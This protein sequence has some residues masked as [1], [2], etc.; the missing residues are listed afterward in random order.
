MEN[1]SKEKKDEIIGEA[2]E[3]PER[4]ETGENK[5][6]PKEEPKKEKD[7]KPEEKKDDNSNKSKENVYDKYRYW[8]SEPPK[9]GGPSG[10]GKGGLRN[11]FALVAL[12]LLLISFF[13]VFFQDSQK[14]KATSISYTE[15][16]SAVERGVVSS[17][18]IVGGTVINFNTNDGGYY[19]TRIPYSDTDLVPQLL[20]YGVKVTGVAETTPF[21]YI[22]LELLPW[23]IFIF[24]MVS[25]MRSTGAMGGGKMMGS[26]GK[27]LAK[28]S[29]LRPCLSM[30]S[31]ASTKTKQGNY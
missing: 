26:L 3:T 16:R 28:E 20:E 5:V 19:T 30:A 4:K 6:D 21:W 29:Q 12:V 13:M 9:N 24:L 22:L 23:I 11:K 17:A 10:S 2:V 1:D 18:D 31:S 7:V 14:A 8:G 15:F 25:M 27:S